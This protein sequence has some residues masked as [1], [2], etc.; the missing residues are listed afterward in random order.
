MCD[1]A[2]SATAPAP[3]HCVYVSIRW[4]EFTHFISFTPCRYSALKFRCEQFNRY[5]YPFRSDYPWW[6][7]MNKHMLIVNCKLNYFQCRN[8]FTWGLKTNRFVELAKWSLKNECSDLSSCLGLNHL[9]LYLSTQYHTKRERSKAHAE[10]M[11][12]RLNE[13]PKEHPWY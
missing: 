2:V 6:E 8:H 5:S 1:E 7:W 11:R 10:E 12:R 4:S 3:T 13:Q 9:S